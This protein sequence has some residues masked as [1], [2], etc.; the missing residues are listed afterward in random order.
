MRRGSGCLFRSASLFSFVVAHS[1][2][3]SLFLTP[4]SSFSLLTLCLLCLLCLLPI[5]CYVTPL[6]RARDINRCWAA[7][8]SGRDACFYPGREADRRPSAKTSPR[9]TVEVDEQEN[10][11]SNYGVGARVRSVINYSTQIKQTSKQ[12]KANRIKKTPL[13]DS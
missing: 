11:H 2:L 5:C 10:R 6:S 1:F 3:L 13:Y 12:I 7:W 4:C 8:M 9:K